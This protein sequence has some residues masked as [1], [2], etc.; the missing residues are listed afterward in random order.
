MIIVRPGFGGEILEIHD[1]AGDGIAFVKKDCLEPLGPAARVALENHA[2]TIAK[3]HFESRIPGIIP[4][5]HQKILNALQGHVS[6]DCR[7]NPLKNGKI[8]HDQS[9]AGSV[10]KFAKSAYEPVRKTDI[11]EVVHYPA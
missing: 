11:A 9:Q 8:V 4:T 5:N 3:K 1:V 2:R 7:T 10:L 6:V